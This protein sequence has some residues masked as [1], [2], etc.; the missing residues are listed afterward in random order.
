MVPIVQ[1]SVNA[2]TTKRNYV[3]LGLDIVLAK[4]DGMAKPAPG[5]VPYIHTERIAR[6]VA[7]AGTTHSVHPSM[8]LAFAR[9]DIVERIAASY[10][11][12]T[13]SEKIVRR[14][15][16]ARTEPAAQL[17]M[18]VVTARLD[19]SVFCAIV[20]ATTSLMARIARTNANALTMLPAT[21]KMARA[22]VQLASPVYYVRIVVKWAFLETDAI[23]VVTVSKKIPWT[24]TPLL[25]IASASQNGEE[26]DAK[27]S[28]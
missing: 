27:Q 20:P 16:P 26:Y 24:V 10:V 17:R 21:H 9:P 2:R 1:R 19:G 6:I 13:P 18:D 11:L 8:A 15:A 12:Q 25:G 5:H 23:R 22:H 28:A 3:I 4:W 14:S 7:I